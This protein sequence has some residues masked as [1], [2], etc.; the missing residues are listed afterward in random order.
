VSRV[1]YKLVRLRRQDEAMHF[2]P[3]AA[4]VRPRVVINAV[5]PLNC[6]DRPAMQHQQWKI[7]VVDKR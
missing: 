2:N 4:Y 1:I 7:S 6:P 3:S 5:R